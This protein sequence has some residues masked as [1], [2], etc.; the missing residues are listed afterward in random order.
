MVHFTRTD[1]RYTCPDCRQSENVTKLVDRL[2]L[3]SS[4]G[5]NGVPPGLVPAYKILCQGTEVYRKQGK[6]TEHTLILA[7]K[8]A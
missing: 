4:Q 1:I 8:T 5:A 2:R 3:C 6:C 7:G